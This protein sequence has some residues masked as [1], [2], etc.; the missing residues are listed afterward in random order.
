MKS[1]LAIWAAMFANLGIAVA[2]FV[3][4]AMT[5]S[6]SMQAEG[7]HSL[8]D[9]INEILLMFGKRQA[10]KPADK[11]RPF[12][13]GR[14]EY[15]WAFI[16]AL[17]VFALGAG[18]SIY[19]GIR[20]VLHPEEATS[21]TIAFAVLGIALVL[22]GTSLFVA[23]RQFASTRG[24]L[25]W[26]AAIRKSKDP[27]L[28]AVLM[29]DTAAV[30]GIVV[31]AA[32]LGLSIWTGDGRWDGVGSI[33]IGLVLA[34]TAILLA[35]ESKALLMGERA[36]PELEASVSALIKANPAV[37]SIGRFRTVQAGPDH[38][39]VMVAANFRDDM[40]VGEL[41][42]LA[43]QL[44]DDIRAAWPTVREIYLSPDNLV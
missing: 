20:H 11:D 28:F 31:A 14:E 37:S 38:V 23:R 10:Q 24:D 26:I 13:Y 4:A 34:A 8:V 18:V 1:N 44:K 27:S 39:V 33:V 35:T 32:A 6:S 42:R 41:E 2:K 9:S 19:Q 36:D 21:P 7:V 43:M 25:G 17:M 15:F 16:V 22:E 29:E 30:I 12:G 5:G 40:T 3:A